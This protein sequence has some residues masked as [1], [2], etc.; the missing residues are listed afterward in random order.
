MNNPINNLTHNNDKFLFTINYPKHSLLKTKFNN[1]AKR[2]Y[3]NSKKSRQSYYREY[4]RKIWKISYV[5][6]VIF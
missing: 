3:C 6:L 2:Q 4:T 1:T 5:K